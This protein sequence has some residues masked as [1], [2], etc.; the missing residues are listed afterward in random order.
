MSSIEKIIE[1][2]KQQSDDRVVVFDKPDV[3]STPSKTMKAS[4][5]NVIDVDFE[6]LGKQGFLLPDETSTQLAEEYRMIKRPLLMNAFGKGAV[7]VENGNLISVASALPGE[8]KTFTSL[9]LAISMAMERDTTVLLVDTDV[10]NPSLS[11][12]FGQE[13]APGLM[14]VLAN[15]D[16]DI[17]DV[18]LKT[19]VDK[20]RFIPAGQR[21]P[22]AA[23]LLASK[24]MTRFAEEIAERYP[25]RI[26][27][28]DAPPILATSH[29]ALVTNL[30]GQ[31]VMVVEAGKTLQDKIKEALAQ[32]S[33]DK[34]IGLVLNKSRKF[35]KHGYYGSYGSYGAVDKHEKPE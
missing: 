14:D 5:G 22:H 20:L 29:S 25:D 11:L 26:I 23:E 12:L 13:E 2:L 27:I 4:T 35:I 30:A 21:N 17:S 9:N 24:R 16:V 33:R 3:A 8:G 31:I 34:V 28:F 32:L 15:D 1:Q 6:S 18:I 7:P 10:T 19:S